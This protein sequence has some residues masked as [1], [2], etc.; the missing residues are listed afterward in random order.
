MDPEIP[1]YCGE[2]TS[3][4]HE[5]NSEASS[6]PLDDHELRMFRTGDRFTIGPM[7][8]VPVHVDH[9]IPGAYGF[10]IHTSEGTLAYTGDFR[11]H[12]R[13]GSMTDDFVRAA[14]ASKPDILLT[15]GT[16]SRPEERGSN[17]S[18]KSVLAETKR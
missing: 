7:E 8:F 15:E 11:F 4:I 14:S 2:T 9:S 6:S 18:E 16:A 3:L 1:I 13:V 17:T 12:G 10:I 5:A